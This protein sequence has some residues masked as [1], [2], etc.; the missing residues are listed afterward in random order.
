MHALFKTVANAL[1]NGVD[2]VEESFNSV[3]CLSSKYPFITFAQNS[4][5]CTPIRLEYQMLE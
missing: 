4:S 1:H 3:E 2:S 5:N